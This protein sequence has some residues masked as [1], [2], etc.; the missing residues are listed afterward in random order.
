MVRLFWPNL[1]GTARGARRRGPVRGSGAGAEPPP[2]VGSSAGCLH[3]DA[4]RPSAVE[5]VPA[6]PAAVDAAAN[7]LIGLAVTTGTVT[8]AAAIVRRV[9]ERGGDSLLLHRAPL[10]D[11]LAGPLQGHL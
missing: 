10:P 2:C 9:S 4:A 3:G 8:D 11:R 5:V 6:G 7:S 1:P